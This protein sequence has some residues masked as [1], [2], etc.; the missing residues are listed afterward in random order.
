MRQVMEV[1]SH[2]S[3]TVPSRGTQEPFTKFRTEP[4]LELSSFRGRA[5]PR[6][7]RDSKRSLGRFRFFTRRCCAFS[8]GDVSYW[9]SLT[10]DRE[11]PRISAGG[12]SAH[13]SAKPEDLWVRDCFRRGIFC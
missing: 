7:S 3:Q 2:G 12:C 6:T 8:A 13:S 4:T 5:V 10:P 9:S 11:K 1:E